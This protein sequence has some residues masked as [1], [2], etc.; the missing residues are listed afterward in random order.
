MSDKKV[1]NAIGILLVF[2]LILLIIRSI[3]KKTE[4][5]LYSEDAYAA[6]QDSDKL[7]ELDKAV[8]SYHNSGKWKKA[9]IN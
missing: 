8:S 3:N 5:K 2:G 7:K 1:L 4:T 6:L 9:T